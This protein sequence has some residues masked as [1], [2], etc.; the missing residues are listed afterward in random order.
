VSDMDAAAD[1]LI[2]HGCKLFSGP[3]V[4]ER[5][6]KAGQAIRYFQA[7]RGMFLEILSRP[8]HMPYERHTNSR[9][10]GPVT[11]GGGQRTLKQET[12]M[13]AARKRQ[14]VTISRTLI[15]FPFFMNGLGVLPQDLTAAALVRAGFTEESVPFLVQAGRAVQLV[16]GLA[17]ASGKFPKCAAA[18]LTAFLI[19][20]TIIVHP[21]WKAADQKSRTR[22]KAATFVNIGLLGALLYLASVHRKA[23]ER[24]L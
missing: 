18:V 14:M 15:A 12:I 13:S 16:A 24:C 6:P 19:G 20:A 10:F 11:V 21:F 2:E 7:P 5:G 23:E 1:Y 9:I 8:A 4:S 3:L 17:L 22:D